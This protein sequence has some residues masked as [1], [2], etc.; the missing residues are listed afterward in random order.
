LYIIDQHAAHERI[1]F[2]RLKRDL[3]ERGLVSQGLLIPSTMELDPHESLAAEKLARPL[4]RLGFRLEPFGG[5]TWVLRG[6]PAL[7]G[8]VPAK[9]ALKEILAAAKGRLRSLEGAGLE[10]LVEDLAGTWLYSLACRAAIK[11]GRPMTAPEM[12]SLIAD[13]RAAGAG[14]Y[15]PH[16]RP[17]VWPIT[18]AELERRFGRS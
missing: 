6:I 17:S 14:G 13:M 11:A 12:D 3:R 10:D 16:G 4:E 18:L 9:E 8:P 2:N 5:S 7:L 1:L 15:C